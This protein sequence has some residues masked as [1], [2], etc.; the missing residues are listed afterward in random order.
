VLA[1]I[2][3]GKLVK[4]E[5]DPDHRWNQGRLCA[6]VPAMTRYVDHPDRYDDP[7]Y[8]VPEC[9]MVWGYNIHDHRS[10]QCEAD[11]R[12]HGHMPYVVAVD[13]FHTPT[14]QYADMLLPVISRMNVKNG[15][16][17]CSSS[18]RNSRRVVYATVG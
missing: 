12:A 6:R 1:H 5:G 8:E 3:D 16:E 10:M 17:P 11:R 7:R 18:S 15:G 9:M 4:I 13:L 14:T 2:K